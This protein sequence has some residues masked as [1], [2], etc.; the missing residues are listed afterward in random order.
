[1]KKLFFAFALLLLSTPVFA[2]YT[3]LGATQVIY[4]TNNLPDTTA[5]LIVFKVV[6][7]GTPISLAP[8]TYRTDSSGYFLGDDGARGIRFRT[9]A[10][11]WVYSPVTIL[12]G[13]SR[14]PQAGTQY[15]VPA[16]TATQLEELIYAITL[17]GEKGDF[18]VGGPS[19]KPTTFGPCAN[20]E[21]LIWDSTQTNG[22]RCASVAGGGTVSSFS[23]GNLAPLFTTSVLNATTAPALSFTL[24]NQSA[25]QV[26]A[27]PTTGA[28]AAPTFRALVAAD[29]PNLASVYQPLDSDLTAIAAL[30]PTDD[31]IIQRKAGAWTNRTVAQF[32]TDLGLA[33]IAT[34]GS[35]SDLSAGTVPLAR[36]SGITTAEL[37]ATAGITNAQLA[38][39]AITIAGTSTSL[40]GS[41]SLDTITGL[42]TT[43]LVKRTAAN[44]L[45]IAT[46]GTDY[47]TGNQTITLSGDVGGSGATAITAAIGANKV[48]NAM[49]AT[50]ATAT[51]KGRTT[52]ATGNVED[53]TATQATALL[54]AMV[55]DSGSGGTKG[56][57]PAPASGD[58]AAGRF[59]KA[60][61]TWAVPPGGGGGSPGG[62]TT[63]LQ[64]N[65]A[66]AFGGI[67]GA[68]SDGTNA[69]FGSGNLRATLPRITT[70]LADAN[71]NTILALAGSGA[72]LG[73]QYLM[74][75]NSVPGDTVYLYG[76][77]PTAD[78]STI[79][80]TSLSFQS[81]NATAGTTNAGAAQGGDIIFQ[82]GDAARLTSGNARGGNMDLYAGS[83]IG[84]GAKGAVRVAKG[85]LQIN[86]GLVR[87]I[88]SVT[89]NAT[90]AE[91]DTRVDVNGSSA[92]TQTL[93][94][95]S[96]VTDGWETTITDVGNNAQTNNITISRAGADTFLGGS[97][98]VLIT[99]NRCAVGVRKAGSVW[100]IF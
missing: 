66:G 75:T 23:A 25:N 98:S 4:G 55:G 59:L 48:T 100:A 13:I 29:I 49:L 67:S 27:G 31:D 74:I 57:A 77:A 54:N 42:S 44:T 61:G 16:S 22:V 60:D 69:T 39:S 43:G 18:L 34:S 90:I 94:A 11:V 72:G 33:A 62:S 63:Q 7:S 93:P 10:Q 46:A 65:N 82:A 73:L 19:G 47:L 87:A 91:S 52:A 95:L 79:T 5:Y 6:L 53:L 1:M 99:C 12:P 24:T 68:T 85:N 35:A 26:F 50:V 17:F 41:I 64:Y 84:T 96:A 15:T 78:L 9:G 28:A 20:S 86:N 58:A 36:L 40:G 76:N 45:A 89:G 8:K 21:T 51:F 70:G 3:R 83:A 88:R 80:G 71:G 81:S 37:S 38:N 30:A 32:K 97:T 14:N 92:N 2:Q 56:L